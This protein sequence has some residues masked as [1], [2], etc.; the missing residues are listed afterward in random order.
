MSLKGGIEQIE[1]LE[2]SMGKY[3]NIPEYKIKSHSRKSYKKFRNRLIR[4]N[5]NF[6]INPKINQYFG[7]EY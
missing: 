6:E 5:K 1:H 3:F 2:Y 4:R 7:Y